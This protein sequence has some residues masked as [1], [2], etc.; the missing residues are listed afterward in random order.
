MA[1]KKN[2]IYRAG[3][4]KRL[5]QDDGRGEVSNSIINQTELIKDYG[6]KHNDIEIVAEYDDM[7]MRKMIQFDIMNPLK[8][9]R[10]KGF[11][12]ICCCQRSLFFCVQV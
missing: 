7:K 8:K 10:N 11:W 6:K 9:C 3:A 4:Y 12:N 5:S 1:K 2:K